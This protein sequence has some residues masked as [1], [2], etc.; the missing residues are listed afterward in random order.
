[1]EKIGQ[2]PMEGWSLH[3]L[4]FFTC[5]NL[6]FTLQTLSE[7]LGARVDLVILSQ[8]RRI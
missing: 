6:D 4:G 3:D 2:R 5:K 8:G 1:M 7:Q